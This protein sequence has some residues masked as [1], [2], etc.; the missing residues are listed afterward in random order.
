MDEQAIVE[1][2]FYVLDSIKLR[3]QAPWTHDW[4]IE[5]D[6][7]VYVQDTLIDDNEAVATV[8]FHNHLT[9]IVP[10]FCLESFSKYN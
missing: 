8:H 10:I 3:Y 7:I 6:C 4:G 2:Q 1:G 9:G 5:Q